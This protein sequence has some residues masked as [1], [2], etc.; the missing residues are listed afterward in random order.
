MAA[1]YQSA[2][3]GQWLRKLSNMAGH[4][5]ISDA[6][7]VDGEGVPFG[8]GDLGSSLL[9]ILGYRER[10]VIEQWEGHL[11]DFAGFK[12]AVNFLGAHWP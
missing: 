1:N 8:D 11:N 4:F 10:K 5:H 9:D 7:G 2:E 3:P 12:T 6:I